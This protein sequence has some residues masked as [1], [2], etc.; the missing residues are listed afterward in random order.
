MRKRGSWK[1]A[2]IAREQLVKTQQAG[3]DL[4][5]AVMICKLWRIA[6]VL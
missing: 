3:K 2:T 1:G 6:M 5:G 4:L